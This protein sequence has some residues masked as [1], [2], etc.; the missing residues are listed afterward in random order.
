MTFTF[1][2]LVHRCRY[3]NPCLPICSLHKLTSSGL[4]PL[5]SVSDLWSFLPSPVSSVVLYH[6]TS[7]QSVCPLPPRR[8]SLSLSLCC[9]TECSGCPTAVTQREMAGMLLLRQ[10]VLVF[11]VR[12]SLDHLCSLCRQWLYLPLTL[13]L[14]SLPRMFLPRDTVSSKEPTTL[15]YFISIHSNE[16]WRKRDW[17]VNK[18]WCVP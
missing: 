2:G 11:H 5:L 7:D 15:S 3:M 13:T 18:M 8:F 17:A 9:V 12:C 14:E 4:Y 16:I 10:S 1:P 6:I